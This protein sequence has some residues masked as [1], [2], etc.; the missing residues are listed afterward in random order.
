MHIRPTARKKK[1]LNP[2]VPQLTKINL[3][4]QY[5]G[6]FFTQ[7]AFEGIASKNREQCRGCCT[8]CGAA[9]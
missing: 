4:K 6:P 3:Q 9:A 1:A 8:P 7:W 2:L 5:I